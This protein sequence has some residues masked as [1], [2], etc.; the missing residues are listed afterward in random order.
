MWTKKSL[1]S[2]RFYLL[3]FVTMLSQSCRRENTQAPKSQ[4]SQSSAGYITRQTFQGHGTVKA[5]DQQTHNI[6]IAHKDI[7]NYME[8][9]TMKFRVTDQAL[10]DGIKA[11][12][13]IDFTIEQNIGTTTIIEIKKREK[14][15]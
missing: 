12:D 10:L 5:I 11:G 2:F 13:E 4:Q 9:M 1:T 3:F 8:A 15:E 6:T 7:P 14:K